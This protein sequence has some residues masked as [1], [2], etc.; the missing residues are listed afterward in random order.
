MPFTIQQLHSRIGFSDAL[1]HEN[2][3]PV[4]NDGEF[5]LSWG[6]SCYATNDPSGLSTLVGSAHPINSI[7]NNERLKLIREAKQNFPLLSDIALKECRTDPLYLALFMKIMGT[8][9]S[10]EEFFGLETKWI[11]QDDDPKTMKCNWD[12]FIASHP[13]SILQ[14]LAL[15]Q[16]DPLYRGLFRRA[17]GLSLIKLGKLLCIPWLTAP[18]WKEALPDLVEL[19]SAISGCYTFDSMK[20]KVIDVLLKHFGSP[21]ADRTTIQ[22]TA[23]LN[24]C[25]LQIRG[26]GE[27][28]GR[29][30]Q[31]IKHYF[32]VDS[33]KG[34]QDD[35]GIDFWALF[36]LENKEQFLQAIPI[37][38]GFSAD[39]FE[40]FLDRMEVKKNLVVSEEVPYGTTIPAAYQKNPRVTLLLKTD[41]YQHLYRAMV[42]TCDQPEGYQAFLESLPMNRAVTK[43]MAERGINLNVW[44]HGIPDRFFVIDTE[45]SQ[46]HVSEPF[47]ETQFVVLKQAYHDLVPCL[48]SPKKFYE[49]LKRQVLGF[50]HRWD[51]TNIS[52][53]F[54]TFLQYLQDQKD[55]K[56][57]SRFLSH[58]LE[59]TERRPNVRESPTTL[60]TARFHIRKI[61][62]LL[63]KSGDRQSFR[64]LVRIGLSSKTSHS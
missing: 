37:G 47:L 34:S 14:H 51:P 30:D 5:S 2:H 8:F 19:I 16:S 40:R 21:D 31:L 57:L 7:D 48:H 10:R 28:G 59:F 42:G 62:N 46:P 12:F 43:Q 53:N 11:N 64:G 54:G 23:H 24:T 15:L 29:F 44:R 6:I 52:E 45:L 60:E 49:E 41:P 20:I 63:R 56:R 39:G 13:E 25:L 61:F 36:I 3:L 26:I 50:D 1:P 55:P 4:P 22:A 18:A 27:I 33:S 32:K 17:L 9:L 35:D 38:T 58:T